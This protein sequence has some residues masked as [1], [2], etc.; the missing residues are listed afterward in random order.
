MK[1]PWTAIWRTVARAR[2]QERDAERSGCAGNLL[3]KTGGEQKG[4][5]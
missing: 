3:K 4:E 5:S 2:A 1:R